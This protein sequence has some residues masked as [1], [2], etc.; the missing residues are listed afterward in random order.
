MT[1]R[2][3]ESF[4]M[5]DLKNKTP[6]EVEEFISKIEL[7][8]IPA[9]SDKLYNKFSKK[10]FRCENCYRWPLNKDCEEMHQTCKGKDVPVPNEQGKPER[11]LVADVIIDITYY[12]CPYCKR[13]TYKDQEI[14]DIK[15]RH[16]KTE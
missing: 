15:N 14:V 12:I 7:K 10:H 6:E 8:W 4:L 1:Q 16:Y 2:E 9:I 11:D 3:F 5:K 13:P